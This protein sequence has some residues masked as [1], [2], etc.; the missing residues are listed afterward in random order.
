[1]LKRRAFQIAKQYCDRVIEADFEKIS[2]A[3]IPKKIFDY[4]LPLDVM[5]HLRKGEQFLSNLYK[6]LKPGGKLIR[7][8]PNFAQISI[9]LSLLLGD[10]TYTHSCIIDC[11]H[12]SFYTGTTLLR[13]LG[14][15]NWTFRSC[16][17]TVNFGQIPFIGRLLK[18]IPKLLE[19]VLT[20]KIHRGLGL[21]WI[22]VCN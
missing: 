17:C 9:I 1:M 22:V 20:T 8:T 13:I 12:I 2:E 21:K 14:C 6:Y 10:F 15:N 3:T 11:T 7:S 4:I 16:T 5:E 19:Y 18:H